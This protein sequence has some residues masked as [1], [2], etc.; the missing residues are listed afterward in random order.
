MASSISSFDSCIRAFTD[1]KAFEGMAVVTDSD[2]DDLSPTCRISDLL[3]HVR[4]RQAPVVS[5]DDTGADA[6]DAIV[7]SAA[8]WGMLRATTYGRASG[9][10]VDAR[11]ARVRPG[12]SCTFQRAH[13]GAARGR[14]CAARFTPSSPSL[15]RRD[16]TV[17]CAATRPTAVVLTSFD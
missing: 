4:P 13:P 5:V 15:T 16:E 6:T 8:A 7:S 17:Q 10:R 14:G 1:L 11:S 9:K 12:G 3:A 2:P